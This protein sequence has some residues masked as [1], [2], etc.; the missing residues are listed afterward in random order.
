MGNEI[1]VPN[2]D[3]NISYK[4]NVNAGTATVIIAGKGKYTGSIK[5]TFKIT[6]QS[7][8]KASVSNIKTKVWTGK[9]QSQSPTV[10]LGKLI[11]KK[12]THYTVS[13]NN[14]KA[15]GIATLII[16][17]KGNYKGTL[18]K[19]FRIN[20]KSTSISKLTAISKGFV[21]T[22]KKQAL[23]TTGY[24]I[25][26]S[27][28]KAFK[29]NTVTKTINKNAVVTSKITGLKSAKIYY[30][31]I[32][33]YKKI[34]NT[35]VYSS[36]S[37]LRQIKTKDVP[38]VTRKVLYMTPGD[39]AKYLGLIKHESHCGKNSE[40]ACY[41]HKGCAYAAQL[42]LVYL[43]ELKNAKGYWDLVI[44][45]DSIA[46][47]GV[48]IGMSKKQ[49]QS[50]LKRNGWI[51]DHQSKMLYSNTLLIYYRGGKKYPHVIELVICIED[52]ILE[53]IRLST[54]KDLNF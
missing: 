53:T 27:T 43:K 48:K 44:K 30:V 13:I 26:Y 20:P 17:G 39:A 3:Y 7:L 51:L 22:W 2:T 24:Q 19:T 8:A 12:G 46:F 54:W 35:N 36:W 28:D 33:T 49:T 1:L 52:G 29:S 50:L 32:R 4:N 37:K 14:N 41:S 40:Y 5:K 23:Q 11:L 34:G 9:A 21:I 38:N 15:A 47:Q 25:Q 42:E 6:P 10:K 16:K 31:R 18:K 45:N